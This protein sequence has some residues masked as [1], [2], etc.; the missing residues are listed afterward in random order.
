[1]K[2]IDAHYFP[3]W[4]RKSFTFTIDDGNVPLDEKFLS[5][6]RPNGILGTFN[7]CGTDLSRYSADFYRALYRGYEI[8]NHCKWHPYAFDPEKTYVFSDETFDERVADAGKL[9]PVAGVRGLFWFRCASGW[10]KIADRACYERLVMQ[11][12]EELEQVFGE[13]R[14]VSFVWPY[15]MQKDPALLSFLKEQ[16]YRSVRTTGCVG[17]RSGFALPADRTRWSYNA[18]HVGL[19]EIGER[20]RAYPDDGELK[21]FCFGVHAHDYENGGLWG[22][23][24][25]F[26]EDFGNRPEEF[27]YATVGDIFAYEDA[28]RA[29]IVTKTEVR[30]E[31]ERTLYLKIDGKRI[32]LMPGSAV[33]LR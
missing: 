23:L 3:G 12:K 30:N 10:R 2:R 27:W 21:F 32:T 29:L 14:I 26:A 4:T 9:Y 7:L 33:S 16:G 1:M 13:G 19:R 28:V 20:Y 5:I 17:D 22:D 11:G 18:H 31:S 15:S 8:A 24:S 25:R 6:V